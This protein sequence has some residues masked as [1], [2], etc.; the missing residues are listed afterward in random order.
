MLLIDPEISNEKLSYVDVTE[1]LKYWS[2]EPVY[3]TAMQFSCNLAATI[4]SMHK[5]LACIV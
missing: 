4:T 2:E 1:P 5:K 3:V